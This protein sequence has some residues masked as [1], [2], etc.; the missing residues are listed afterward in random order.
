MGA[1]WR[2]AL[3]LAERAS[4][5]ASTTSLSRPGLDGEAALVLLPSVAGLRFTALLRDGRRRGHNS[6]VFARALHVSTKQVLGA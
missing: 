3:E 4:D 2:L 6:F 5:K 1:F